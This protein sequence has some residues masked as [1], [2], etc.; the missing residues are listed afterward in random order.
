MLARQL[1][2]TALFAAAAFG[3]PAADAN[4]DRVFR[5]TH[6]GTVQDIQ[7]IAA[8]I[9]SMADIRQLSADT[10]QKTLTLRGTTAQV[11]LAEWLFYEFDKPASRPAPSPGSATREYRLSDGGE[12]VTR[13]FQLQHTQSAQGLQEV[14]TLVRSMTD[15][16][17]LFI[18]T[19][20]KMMAL[21]GTEAQVKFAE[22]L[23]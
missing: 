18:Y 12:D 13:V 22:W 23:W 4:Q 9:R 21:R 5:F 6:T 20:P 14:A 7:E 8:T 10:T 2:I 16:R 15:I 3:Q 1:V 19:A 17:R 11:G